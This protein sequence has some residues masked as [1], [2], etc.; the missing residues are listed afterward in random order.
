MNSSISIPFEDLVTQKIDNR[1]KTPPVVD[2]GYPLLEVNAI[3][4]KSI[5]PDVTKARKFVDQQ[6][7]DNWFRQHLEK[8]DILFTTVGTIAESAIVPD[9]PGYGI[10]Q[11]ILGFRFDRSLIDPFFALYLMRSKWFIDQI[12]GRTIE[13][14][15]KSIK[16]ADMRKIQI[17][18][19]SLDDQNSIV[20]VAKAIDEKIE[21]N[22]KINETLEKTIQAL[23]GEYFLNQAEIKKWPEIKI[24][25]VVNIK[26]GGTPSTKNPEFWNGDISWTSPRD[27][28]GKENDAFLLN[29]D[30]TIAENG[31]AT[32]SS[33]LL[34]VGTL[35][36]SSRAPIGYIAISGIPLAINQGYIAFLPDAKLSNYFMFIWLKQNMH[37]IKSAANGSTFMEISKSAFRNITMVL[38][39]SSRLAEFD[40]A[41]DPLF[42]MMKK[43]QE[44]TRSLISTRNT[45]LPRL[46]SGKIKV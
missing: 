34:P 36:L 4:T 19:P 2:S 15:Q 25:Q 38:P 18:L 32:I 5:Y 41:V 46:I 45:L 13:T 12:S 31:L 1:G 44:E 22:S 16:W 20:R 3:S 10:A 27:L 40:A 14:V 35:L 30:K 43:N 17:T 42:G 8:D 21:L 24:G 9:K 11:N 33:G 39:D 29:T 23:F 7:W 28:T 37:R 26:G 6:T